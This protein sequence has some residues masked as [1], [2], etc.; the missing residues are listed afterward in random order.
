MN[1]AASPKPWR[2]VA[3]Y[4]LCL[5]LCVSAFRRA[6]AF[7]SLMSLPSSHG[8]VFA[9]ILAIDVLAESAAAL[10]LLRRS[11]RAYGLGLML[12]LQF[13]NIALLWAYSCDDGFMVVCRPSVFPSNFGIRG[14]LLTGTLVALLATFSFA[15]SYRIATVLFSGYVGVLGCVFACVQYER[16]ED[17]VTTLYKMATASSRATLGWQ[18]PE[19]LLPM[20]GPSGSSRVHAA[21]VKRP[22]LVLLVDPGCHFCEPIV[23]ELNAVQAEAVA[24]GLTVVVVGV[25]PDPR[26][27]GE[28]MAKCR[29]ADID[30][31][32]FKRHDH[33]YR[34]GAPS[35][36]FCLQVDGEDKVVWRNKSGLGQTPSDVLKLMGGDSQLRLAAEA[37]MGHAVAVSAEVV[38]RH[39]LTV[40]PLRESDGGE[41][42]LLLC[43]ASSG[44]EKRERLDIVVVLRNANIIKARV[45][46][47]TVGR[48][49]FSNAQSVLDTIVGM[50]LDEA[51]RVGKERF[52]ANTLDCP[53]WLETTSLL[54]DIQHF[55]KS[56]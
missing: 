4:V 8:S 33:M 2:R 44:V 42:G 23:E 40:V 52:E 26:L 1:A 31:Y 18:F 13:A 6:Q 36:P 10:L 39:G 9:L 30:L 49:P 35:V 34:L 46:F 28:I 24:R 11:G 29:A 12:L 53:I 56:R 15:R 21:L 5:V 43:L 55:L 51:A 38:S 47:S 25:D 37:V 32:L 16:A 17:E 22:A 41:E 48:L 50:S 54:S 3:D 7:C 14:Q 20:R 19:I 27:Y 45:V